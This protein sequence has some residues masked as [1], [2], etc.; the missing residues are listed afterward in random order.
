MSLEQWAVLAAVVLLPLLDGVAR[1]RRTRSSRPQNSRP[2]DSGTVPA[3][4]TVM[5]PR[6]SPSPALPAPA[7]AE[8]VPLTRIGAR[9]AAS[10]RSG[11]LKTH[12]KVQ[13]PLE[14]HSVVRWL[15]PVRNRRRAIVLATIL[16][17]PP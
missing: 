9:H 3:Q 7:S 2:G 13:R 15:R 10:A 6:P 14:G 16:S 1:L 4:R 8:L 17:R 11:L 12:K 5:S